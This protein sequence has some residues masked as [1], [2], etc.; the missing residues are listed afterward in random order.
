[1]DIGASVQNT[2]DTHLLGLTDPVHS[3][4]SLQ[5]MGGVESGL[6]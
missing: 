1:M 2:K 3:S 4:H 6:H 5:F